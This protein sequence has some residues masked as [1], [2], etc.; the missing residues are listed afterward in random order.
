[1]C[2][3]IGPVAKPASNQRPT[4]SAILRVCSAFIDRHFLKVKRTHS[5][6]ARNIDAEL[7]RRRTALV[8]GV[9]TAAGTEVMLGF[10]SVELVKRQ[11]LFALQH[12]D[13]VQVGRYRHCTTHAAIGTVASAGGA[14]A[15]G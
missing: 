6:N 11:R 13:V 3:R 12:L 8:K 14:Q 15:I 10:A 4:S 9:D 1:M 2:R 5:F 7:V